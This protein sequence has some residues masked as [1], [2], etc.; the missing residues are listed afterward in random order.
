MVRRKP[1]ISAVSSVRT[2]IT[3]E[4]V[5]FVVYRVTCPR[6]SA[7]PRA[8][9][10]DAGVRAVSSEQPL[11]TSPLPATATWWGRADWGSNAEQA[12]NSSTDA[13]VEHCVLD[14]SE[15]VKHTKATPPANAEIV[16]E[17]DLPKA[18]N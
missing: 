3:S 6:V 11:T 9:L 2:Y 10:C 8:E 7:A 5:H 14:K 18:T 4:Y 17:A 16:K 12:C 15:T 13:N 1:L